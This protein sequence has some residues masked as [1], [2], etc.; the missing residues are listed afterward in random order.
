MDRRGNSS[1]LR[2]RADDK[3]AG[4][5]VASINKL[6][7]TTIC[8]QSGWAALYDKTAKQLRKS[9]PIVSN[10]SRRCPTGEQL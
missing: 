9:R 4:D 6:S 8:R 1:S 7:P 3:V 2:V 10:S 5:K